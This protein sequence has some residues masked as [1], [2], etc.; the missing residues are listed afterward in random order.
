MFYNWREIVKQSVM[1]L[2]VTGVLDLV[3]GLIL[4]TR[5]REALR[6][7]ILLLV[8][9]SFINASGDI[10]GVVSARLASA[11]HMGKMKPKWSDPEVL[12]NISAAFT[13]R[14]VVTLVIAV[15]AHLI[16]PLMATPTIGLLRLVKIIVASGLITE[17]IVS[18]VSV[19]IAFVSYDKGL[20]PNNISAPILTSLGDI[21]GVYILMVV[22]T[23]A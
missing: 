6:F 15:S 8:L 11:L 19:L 16:A 10:G 14:I 13:L 7:P 21:V 20:D 3:A 1:V 2:L 12:E 5:V 18:T 22:S 9:P 17:F 23:I 4:E